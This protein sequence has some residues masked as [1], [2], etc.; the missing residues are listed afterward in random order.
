MP[1]NVTFPFCTTLVAKIKKY[2]FS[3]EQN[4]SC[5][6]TRIWLVP[7]D[8]PRRS[9]EASSKRNGQVN[10]EI[11]KKKKNGTSKIRQVYN[12]YLNTNWGF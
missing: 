2:L 5:V 10:L 3:K 12:T 8:L 4:Y 9:L 7:G 1:Y 11:K 6:A